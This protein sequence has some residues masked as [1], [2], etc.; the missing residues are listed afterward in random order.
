MKHSHSKIRLLVTSCLKEVAI[1]L[2]PQEHYEEDTIKEVHHLIVDSFQYL[3]KIN[4]R[5]FSR[6]VVI[7]KSF[8]E[9]ELCDLLL[10]L[11]LHDLI[12]TKFQHFLGIIGKEHKLSWL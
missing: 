11:G 6:K 1:I 5:R 4:S 3:G 10:A 8:A 12:N 7:P 9:I 2:A